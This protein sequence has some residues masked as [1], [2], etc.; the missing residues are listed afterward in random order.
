MKRAAEMK[1]VARRQFES[2]AG[3]YD[4]SLL[5]H[6]LF[7]P[8]YR[9]VL[10]ELYRWRGRDR[11]PFRLLDVGCGT[12]TLSALL[13]RSS[14]RA[15][16][17]GLDY[18]PGMCVQAAGKVRRV[19]A[20]GSARFVAGDSE[21]LPF[22]DASFDVVTCANSFHHYPNQQGAIFEMRRVLRPGGRLMVIDGFRDNV[23]GWFVFDVC[24]AAVEG[25]VH[26]APW[27][28]FRRYFLQA[29][30]RDVRHRKFNWW[31][32]AVLTVGVAPGR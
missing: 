9:V 8:G 6:F 3:S 13:A 19:G 17:V 5:N 11:G 12:G 7:R 10:E 31:F 27:S 20:D 1:S 25:A 29:G 24:I 14:L 4:R 26:H 30:F 23:V 21:Y 28:Q 15:E 18:S 2:W 16:I 22:A 32:P